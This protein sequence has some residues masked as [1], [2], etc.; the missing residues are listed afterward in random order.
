M[1]RGDKIYP[2][3]EPIIVITHKQMMAAT[4]VFILNFENFTLVIRL[5]R[6]FMVMERTAAIKKYIINN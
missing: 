4:V 1:I 2:I 5:L 3:N 6:G